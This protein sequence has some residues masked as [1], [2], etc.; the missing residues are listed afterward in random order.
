MYMEKSYTRLFTEALVTGQE[1]GNHPDIY[2]HSNEQTNC[3]IPIH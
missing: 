3:A 1:T 2:Q